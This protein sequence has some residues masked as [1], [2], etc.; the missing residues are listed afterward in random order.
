MRAAR[1]A[2]TSADSATERLTARLEWP[3][4]ASRRSRMGRPAVG[5]DVAYCSAAHIL[6]ACTGSTRLSLS[7]TVNR[8]LG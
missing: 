1:K 4:S 7:N 3:T 8:T 6:R 2:R 5:A